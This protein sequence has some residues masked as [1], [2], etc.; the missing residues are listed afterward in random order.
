MPLGPQHIVYKIRE[1]LINKIFRG[2]D[3]KIKNPVAHGNIY[4]FFFQD[5][6][7]THM[8]KKYIE[9]AYVKAGW[10]YAIY[11]TFPKTRPGLVRLVLVK[12]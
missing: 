5:E 1:E 3:E 6:N 8:E 4:H 12:P 11:E 9:D 2:I 7:L 10:K